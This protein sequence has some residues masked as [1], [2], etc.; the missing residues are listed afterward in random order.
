[1][2]EVES[3]STYDV[4]NVLVELSL[5]YEIEMN[6]EFFAMT[7]IIDPD[8]NK[9]KSES[10]QTALRMELI[11]KYQVYNEFLDID[12]EL[13]DKL[14]QKCEGNPLLCISTAYQLLIVRSFHSSLKLGVGRTI[15]YSYIS[16][17]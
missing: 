11:Q 1:M 17:S 12:R 6:K 9:V 10:I 7:R 8:H 14:V 2:F 5:P 4:R 13:L 16:S 3:L 15:S